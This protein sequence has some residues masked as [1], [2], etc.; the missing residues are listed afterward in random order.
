MQALEG[1]K[2]F[3]FEFFIYIN[4]NVSSLFQF[5]TYSYIYFINGLILIWPQ[6]LCF[7]WSMGCIP[8]I[9]NIYDTRIISVVL[10]WAVGIALFYRIISFCNKNECIGFAF[11]IVPFIPA[12]NLLFRVGFVIAERILFLPSSGMC[13]LIIT[14]WKK[15]KRYQILKNYSNI[16][17]WL[18]ITTYAF[19]SHERSTEWLTEQDLF[20]S[21]LN[22]CSNNA[23]VHYNIAKVAGD[24]GDLKQAELEYRTALKLYP[25]YDQAMNNLANLLKNNGNLEEAKELLE[26]A[27][28]LRTDFAA[29]WM[30]LGIVYA[31][32]N[33]D[34][35]AESCYKMALTHRRQYADCFYNLGNLVSTMVTFIFFCNINLYLKKEVFE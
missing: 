31:M 6:W 8:L 7:D 25:N 34:E 10:F 17:L 14:G 1:S 24:K 2:L 27:V 19:R 23:K 30:N 21:A 22:V 26:K 15:L 3:H 4:I 11:L 5:L 20:N 16:I 33:E 32:L 29:A 13:I 18:V 35:K 12:S 9:D 28:G